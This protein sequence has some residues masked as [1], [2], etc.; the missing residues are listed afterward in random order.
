LSDHPQLDALFCHN[1]LVAVG[2]MQAC[3]ALGRN[4]PRDVAVVGYDDVPLAAL[5]TPT[6]TTCHVPRYELGA[7]AAKLLLSQ[8]NGGSTDTQPAVIEPHLVVRASAP[9][10]LPL[11]ER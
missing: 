7:Q 10:I 1:D 8:V 3:A 5:V 9:R 4:V 11:E 6:L 2:A